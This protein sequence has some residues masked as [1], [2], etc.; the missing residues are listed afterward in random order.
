M[1]SAKSVCNLVFF[2][3]VVFN[4]CCFFF[5]QLATELYHNMY[6]LALYVY[7]HK[8]QREVAAN[9]EPLKSSEKL[10]CVLLPNSEC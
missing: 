10:C 8:H 3:I 5:G 9:S 6:H 2:I 7:K 4:F 1:S